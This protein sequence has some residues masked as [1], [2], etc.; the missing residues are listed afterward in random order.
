MALAVHAVC[1]IA[2]H[3]VANV[4]LSLLLEEGKL[5]SSSWWGAKSHF[6]RCMAACMVPSLISLSPGLITLLLRGWRVPIMAQAAA[7]P[8]VTPSQGGYAHYWVHQLAEIGTNSEGR[9]AE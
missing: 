1:L 5:V 6:L 8:A 7:G 9:A 3:L 2:F 4:T